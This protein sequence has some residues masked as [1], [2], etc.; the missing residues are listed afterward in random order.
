MVTDRATR[1]HI[2]HPNPVKSGMDEASKYNAAWCGRYV[3]VRNMLPQEKLKGLPLAV[4]DS[5][6]RSCVKCLGH[7]FDRPAKAA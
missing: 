4:W 1:I 2:A 5:L 7:T 6:C 3:Q